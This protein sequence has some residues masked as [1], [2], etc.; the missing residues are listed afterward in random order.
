MTPST[1]KINDNHRR[2]NGKTKKTGKR[3][4]R[5]SIV[6]TVNYSSWMMWCEQRTNT[7]YNKYI[8]VIKHRFELICSWHSK[9]NWAVDFV[10]NVPRTCYTTRTCAYQLCAMCVHARTAESVLCANVIMA[11][12]PNNLYFHHEECGGA[13]RNGWWWCAVCMCRL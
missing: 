6:V 2:S 8:D 13:D 10:Q 12:T 4:Q 9:V 7:Q 11:D 1:Y 5:R 3:R